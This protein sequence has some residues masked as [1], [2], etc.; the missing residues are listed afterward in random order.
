[1][2]VGQNFCKVAPRG[3]FVGGG[4]DGGVAARAPRFG[5]GVRDCAGLRER[6]GGEGRA[7]VPGRAGLAEARVFCLEKS[8]DEEV[9]LDG[10]GDDGGMAAS[11]REWRAA[12]G[13]DRAWRV[14]RD[15]APVRD[16]VRFWGSFGTVEDDGGDGGGE[17]LKEAASASESDSMED[18]VDAAARAARAALEAAHA[19]ASLASLGSFLRTA[20]EGLPRLGVGGAFDVARKHRGSDRAAV[21]TALYGSSAF[22]YAAGFFLS[23]TVPGPLAAHAAHFTNRF[24]TAFVC[25]L[26]AGESP[27]DP[28]VVAAALAVCAGADGSLA[29]DATLET[30]ERRVEVRRREERARAAAEEERERKQSAPPR[31]ARRAEEGR[32]RRASNANSPALGWTRRCASRWWI[33]PRSSGAARCA[34]CDR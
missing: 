18:R 8:L 3:G 7:R 1:M 11:F 12:W 30:S 9:R 2:A 28:R 24:R 33:P 4:G 29:L 16:C 21:A 6:A 32:R 17:A 27:L 22:E 5:L 15:Y 23:W 25:A 34:R 31:Q 26:L 14:A 20:L 13:R 10:G 19:E